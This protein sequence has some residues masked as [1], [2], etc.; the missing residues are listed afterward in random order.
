MPFKK[1]DV[2]LREIAER[3]DVSNVLEGSV[4][5]AGDRVR[6]VVQLVEASCDRTLWAETYDRKLDDIFAIQSEI[7][8]AIASALRSELT[9]D[10]KERIDKEPTNNV[11]A[12]THFLRGRQLLT[13]WY[14]RSMMRSLEQFERAIELDPSFALA[15]AE[16]AHAYCELGELG[17]L[18][19][20]VAYPRAQAS[21]AR[22]LTLDPELAEGYMARGYVKVL[23]EY[24]WAGAEAD[25]RRALELKPG[26]ADAYDIYGRMCGALGRFDEGVALQE[27]AFELD[28]VTHRTDVATSLL[29]A[30]R[31]IEAE[32]AARRSLALDP[33]Y[34]RAIATL[35]WA[36]FRQGKV[37][38]GLRS[39]ERAV[40]LAPGETIWE[41]Q[42][43]QALGL[44]GRKEEARAILA[45]LVQRNAN[46]YH[47]AYIEIGLGEF[48]K[49]LDLLEK[50][51]ETKSA[52]AYGIKGSFLWEPVREHPRFQALLRK[53]HLA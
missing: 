40:E 30:G 13:T 18:D 50:A 16:L 29:R 14:E 7:A 10:E 35:G 53:I 32:A 12:Y 20:Q 36:L 19:G 37:D 25:F 11:E 46:P 26:Y 41:G 43:G 49:A 33:A 9:K 47:T 51:I 31:P 8:V 38:E 22:A 27:R 24:D 48:D 3:L 15:H 23:H 17:D 52:A 6:V 4:R 42:L 45:R 44:L 21:A 5:R 1:R 34:A 28:P 39:L 2:P